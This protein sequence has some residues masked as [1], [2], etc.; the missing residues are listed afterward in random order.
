[1]QILNK[2]ILL[3]LPIVVAAVVLSGMYITANATSSSTGNSTLRQKTYQTE[4]ELMG[5]NS[6]G[7]R[8]SR[9]H[10]GPNGNIQVSAA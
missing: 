9:M 1:M 5:G 8:G 6:A 10:G 3:L 7:F 2:K 4:S